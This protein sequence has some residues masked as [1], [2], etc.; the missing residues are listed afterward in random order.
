MRKTFEEPI[1]N[2]I[3]FTM[4]ETVTTDDEVFTPQIS[5]GVEE[6]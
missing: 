4:N 2:V 6:W 5:A 3:K 1:L